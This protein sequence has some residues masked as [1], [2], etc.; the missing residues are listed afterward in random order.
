MGHGQDR[1]AQV[2]RHV[3]FAGPVVQPDLSGAYAPVRHQ[4]Q[5]G[6]EAVAAGMGE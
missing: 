4:L 3:R 6:T 1:L 5:W 2:E